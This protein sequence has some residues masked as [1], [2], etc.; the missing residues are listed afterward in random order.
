MQRIDPNNPKTVNVNIRLTFSQKDFLEKVTTN[1][2]EFIRGLID[3]EMNKFD[4]S[5]LKRKTARASK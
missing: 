4:R 2:S 5:E 3:K 1:N